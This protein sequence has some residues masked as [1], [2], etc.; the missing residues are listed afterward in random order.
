[1]SRFDKLEL[2]EHDRMVYISSTRHDWAA[3]RSLVVS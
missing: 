3:I 2:T 1:M